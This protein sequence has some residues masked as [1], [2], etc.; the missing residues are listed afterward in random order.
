MIP[1]ASNDRVGPLIARSRVVTRA[2]TRRRASLDSIYIARIARTLDTHA[3]TITAYVTYVP[4]AARAMDARRATRAPE[5]EGAARW[6]PTDRPRP[7]RMG[8]DAPERVREDAH[9]VPLGA[10]KTPSHSS[11]RGF[12]QSRCGDARGRRKI[13]DVMMSDGNERMT[14]APTRRSGRGGPEEYGNEAYAMRLTARGWRQREHST[15]ARDAGCVRENLCRAS[16]SS[17]RRWRE[18]WRRRRYVRK[19][20]WRWVRVDGVDAGGGD[21]IV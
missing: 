19:R 12:S 20:R 7:A 10:T 3:E 1:C 14:D 6:R 4:A 17:S 16:S 2:I 21:E 8:E 11:R 15:N 9:V 18:L 5:D 13:S